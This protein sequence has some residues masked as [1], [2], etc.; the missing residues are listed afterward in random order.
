MIASGSD[1]G[2]FSIRDL[3]LIKVILISFFCCNLASIRYGMDSDNWPM[4]FYL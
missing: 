1:D 3:R 4:H 2:T